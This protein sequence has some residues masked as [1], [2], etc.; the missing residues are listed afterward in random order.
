MGSTLKLLQCEKFFN[1]HTLVISA[2][3]F[4]E[5]CDKVKSG[6]NLCPNSWTVA[7]TPMRRRTCTALVIVVDGVGVDIASQP[8]VMEK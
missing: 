1:L 6:K 7:T 3:L 5:F 4:K 2:K 8:L